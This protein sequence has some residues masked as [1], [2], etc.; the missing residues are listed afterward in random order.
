MDIEDALEIGGES[1]LKELMRK[2]L[3]KEGID[4]DNWQRKTASVL[5]GALGTLV[6]GLLGGPIG[7]LLGTMLWG[8]AQTA[9]YDGDRPSAELKEKFKEAIKMKSIEKSMQII[10]DISPSHLHP[11]FRK[12]FHSEYA[13]HAHKTQEPNA[14]E[15]AILVRKILSSVDYNTARKFD[16]LYSAALDVI[17]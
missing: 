12:A 8:V 1:I 2:E 16:K 3:I 6:G 5:S 14:E 9:K 13:L 10:A 15:M 11:Q 7:M 4:V 17:G